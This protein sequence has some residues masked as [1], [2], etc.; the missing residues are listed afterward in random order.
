MTIPKTVRDILDIREH[1]KI[2][3]VL[4]KNGEVTVKREQPKDIWSLAREQ[5][6]K[7]GSIDTPEI[8]WG[9]DVG[10]EVID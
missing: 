8:D 4:R 5:A 10:N 6:V 1:D 9:S 2:E 7:Y 3:F